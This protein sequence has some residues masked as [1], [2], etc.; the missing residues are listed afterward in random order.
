[1]TASLGWLLGSFAVA[2][3]FVLITIVVFKVHPFL[4]L[5]L[6]SI[7]MGLCSKMAFND[8]AAKI[9]SGFGGTLGSIGIIIVL[10]IILGELL[11][12][13]GCTGQIAGLLLR[14]TGEKRAPFAI[15]LTG[16][17]V[18]IPVFFD[19]AFILLLSLIKQVSRKGKIPFI[20]LVTA[21]AIGLITTHAVV[22]PTPGPLIVANNLNLNLG[23]FLFYSLIVAIAGSLVGGVVYGRL[24]GSLPGN[25]TDFANNFDDLEENPVS[26]TVSKDGPSGE[27]GI[28]LIFL[29]IVIIL[30]GTIAA[31]TI[32]DKTST[33][34]R[35]LAFLGDKN[36]ALLIGVL[37]AYL[38][39]HGH[40]RTSFSELISKC[41]EHAG[42]IFIITGAGGAFGSVINA[43][44]IGKALVESMSGWTGT[45]AGLLLIVVC[46]AISQILRA[47]QGSTT[48]ALVTTSS[49]M[50]PIV[51][52]LSGVSPVLIGLAI[53]AGGIGC[54]LPNDSGF[55]VVNRFSSFSI[56]QTMQCWTIGGTISGLTVLACLVVLNFF[57][58]VLPGL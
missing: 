58:G 31:A 18:S 48:V 26:Q 6:G 14:I 19:A 37:V 10:G 17:I 49:I 22:I 1:M 50:A 29:P 53:C 9:A 30:A 7:V 8:I 13:S 32:A 2:I 34:Y 39:L 57:A 47:A 51:A 40:I 45:S 21:L 12:Q 43:T 16:F 41:G 5:L 23:Y 11:H 35:V 25:A 38:L 28:F 27:L 54:S 52:R 24:I 56:K 3:F 46:F 4:S 15:N 20:T 33:S 42:A 55:W 44:G 36:I